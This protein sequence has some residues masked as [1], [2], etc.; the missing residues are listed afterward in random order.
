MKDGIQEV[1][2]LEAHELSWALR[3]VTQANSEVTRELGRRLGLGGNDM[4]ALDHLFQNGPLGPAE[5]GQLLGMRSASATVLVD[6]LEA[7]G[8]VER[9]SHPTDRRRLI[10]EPTPHAVEE[11][12]G[13]IRPLV[14]NLDAV[15]EELTPDERQIVAQ[16]LKRVSDVLGS[17]A[18]ED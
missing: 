13:L 18:P 11:V 4:T 7:A 16:Y 17:Y 3:E 6:R 15:A 1:S 14:A 9:R 10:V 5:L 2:Y 8:H 12:L